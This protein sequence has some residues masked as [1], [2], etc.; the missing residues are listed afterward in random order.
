VQAHR[1]FST[2]FAFEDMP[3]TIDYPGLL[4][5]IADERARDPAGIQVSNFG[6]WHSNFDMLDWGGEAARA[7][8]RRAEALADSLTLNPVRPEQ[9]RFR[10]VAEMWANVSFAGHGH[11]YHFHPGWFWSAVAYLDD[12]YDGSDLAG[13]GG[14]LKL[15]DPR[16]PGNRMAAPGWRVREAN[17]SEQPADLAVRPHKGLLVL[18][19]SWLQHA[20]NPLVT[21]GQRVSL[22]MNLMPVRD[23]PEPVA[24]GARRG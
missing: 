7:V 14:E 12:G 24:G 20:V 1:L 13:L 19:P 18:F 21:A 16:M 2:P 23:A 10:W 22:A 11:E 15:R 17:G 8:V 3:S 5:A 4:Q 9:T 6:G